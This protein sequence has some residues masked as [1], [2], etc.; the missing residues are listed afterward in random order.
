[1][2]TH[3]LSATAEALRREAV[4]PAAPLRLPPGSFYCGPRPLTL[5]EFYELVDEDTNAELVDGVIIMGLPASTPHETLADFLHRLVGMYV[6]QKGLGQVLGSR[7]VIRI[8]GHKG[9]EP[10]L[11]F[12]QADR[13][14]ILQQ[15]EIVGP[16][17]LVV[18]IISPGDTSREVIT[19]QAEYEDLGVR[20]Y[21]QIDQPRQVLTVYVRDEAGRFAPVEP[22]LQGQVHST[23]VS[24]FWLWPA[25]LW[26]EVEQF[27]QVTACLREIR[28]AEKTA[29]DELAALREQI[30][31]ERFA[32]FLQRWLEGDGREAGE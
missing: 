25:W 19:Q 32:Q 1:M 12:V 26:S 21:W 28:G 4:W 15:Q 20:E 6:E 14:D 10:D 31:P 16:P 8:T 22:D 18:E 30:G 23:V 24:G 13:L 3:R 29:A 2:E 7:S 9:R 17:D 27:P 5:E 11:L